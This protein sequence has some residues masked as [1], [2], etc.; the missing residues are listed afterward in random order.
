MTMIREL[1]VDLLDDAVGIDNT[2]PQFGWKL[3]S[4]ERNFIQE[5][6]QIRVCDRFTNTVLWDSGKVNSEES[7]F[8]SYK[9][10]QLQ[11]RQCCEWNVRVW[12]RSGQDTGWSESAFFEMGL[13]H[14]EDWKAMWIEPVQREVQKEPVFD[15]Q[16]QLEEH[17]EEAVHERL[18][19][20]QFCRREII[21]EKSI[22]KARIYAT[23]HG[24]YELQLNGKKA[25]NLELAPGFTSYSKCLQYQTYDITELLHLGTNVV[26][27][28]LA[29]G[30]YAG[31]IGMIGDS[32]Q[33]GNK[34]GA[35]LQIEIDYEDGSSVIIGSD[36]NFVSSTG[37]YLYSDLYIGEKADYRLQMEGWSEP[38]FDAAHWMP[39]ECADYGYDNL[40]AQMG[41]PVRVVDERDAVSVRKT[42]RGELV[43]DFGQVVA[44]RVRLEAEGEAGTE[45]ILEHSEVLDKEGN[46]LNNIVGR[47][48]DQR[49]IFILKGKGEEILEPKFTFHGFRYVKVSGYPGELKKEAAKAIVLSSDMK[50]NGTFECS[51]SRLN[52][53]QK[54]IFHSQQGNMISIPTDCPQRE[55]A[56]WT[57]DIQIFAPTACHN[58]KMYSFLKRWLRNVR[59]EQ[60]DN[61][62]IPN[63]VPFIP[64]YNSFADG[65]QMPAS[66]GWGDA[67]VIVP[68]VL[69]EQ[70]GSKEVLRENYQTMK[71]WVEYIRTS[72]ENGCSPEID[73]EDYE[74]MERQK[75]L[76]NTGQNLGDWLIPSLVKDASVENM[77]KCS[78]LTQEYISSCFY[79]YSAEILSKA[80]AVLGRKED[81]QYYSELAEKVRR[82]F[83]DEY[84]KEDGYLGGI[85]AIKPGY[86]KIRIA[87]H[88]DCGLTS[89][90]TERETVYGR[91]VS[92]WKLNNTHVE[93]DVTVPENTT[94]EIVLPG[95]AGVR[96]QES[97]IR[98]ET[99]QNILV[100]PDTGNENLVCE[101][102][103]GTYQFCYPKRA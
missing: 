91:I 82:A 23:A 103:S 30:W 6:Y 99:V 47:N 28:I 41:E 87:P 4:E 44:G 15:M 64:S 81:Q 40:Y 29:D 88:I 71:K 61:G 3:R 66:A 89:V 86:R 34:L 73:P 8:I 93:I 65:E 83:S 76:W 22:Q 17:G 90:R 80:A 56:G 59:M 69:Y 39:V 60:Y 25:G 102:G 57:G 10:K 70:Y 75:Y 67:C 45:I 2:A 37:E 72:A 11:S 35:L 96:I 50:K 62:G 24:V 31:R 9:G 51:D 27:I 19:P 12:D 32:A 14:Q 100:S 54:N 79:V 101:V 42:P 74:R 46:Y 26:G 94:A 58:M 98:L 53:L 85:S 84:I 68:W 7:S 77:L 16:R 21:V 13:L 20:C 43:L 97:G 48:K 92:G 5:A 95:A 78:S 1:T 18:N 36:K 63:I 33:Y 52:R 55:R 49:D 38:G